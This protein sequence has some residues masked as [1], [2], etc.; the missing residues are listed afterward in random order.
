[1][2]VNKY[3][4]TTWLCDD[5]FGILCT[6]HVLVVHM[7]LLIRLFHHPDIRP[8]RCHDFENLNSAKYFTNIAQVSDLLSYFQKTCL[9]VHTIFMILSNIY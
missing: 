7:Y 3:T 6:G 4:T 2:Y 5:V 8:L 9:H 1:M